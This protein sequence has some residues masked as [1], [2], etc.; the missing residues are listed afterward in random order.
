MREFGSDKKLMLFSKQNRME[1]LEFYPF[2]VWIEISFYSKIL[3][4][5]TIIWGKPVKFYKVRK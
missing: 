5:N 1:K 2:C 4:A 3:L